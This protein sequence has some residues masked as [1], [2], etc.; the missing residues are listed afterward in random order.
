MTAQMMKSW[1]HG[2]G[3]QTLLAFIA[4]LCLILLVSLPIAACVTGPG[5]DSRPLASIPT[6]I[7]ERALTE[8]RATLIYMFGG[9]YQARDSLRS[10]IRTIVDRVVAASDDPSQKYRI[11]ILNSSSPNAFALPNGELYVTRGLLALANDL[12]ELLYIDRISDK[13]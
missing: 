11:T 9:E 8:E 2:S 5:H 6:G 10:E 4:R 1:K 12:F 13:R 7:P 3:D